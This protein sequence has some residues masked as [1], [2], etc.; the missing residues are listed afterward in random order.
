MP[1]TKPVEPPS[2]QARNA[3][4][5]MARV[6]DSPLP[7]GTEARS[8]TITGETATVDFNVAFKENFHGGDEAEALALNSVLATMGQFA[9]VHRVQITVEGKTID[10]L[11]GN[12]SLTHALPVPQQ[13]AAREVAP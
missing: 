11:G 6:K 10:S 13:T 5:V 1:A 8:V 3:L 7:D 4:N 9:G 2:T 12:Q